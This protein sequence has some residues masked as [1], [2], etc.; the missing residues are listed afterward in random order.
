MIGYDSTPVLQHVNNK[1]I[2]DYIS[3]SWIKGA[4]YVQFD[5]SYVFDHSQSGKWSITKNNRGFWNIGLLGRVKLPFNFDISTDLYLYR[6]FG[7]VDRSMNSTDLLWT[8]QLGYSIKKDV[9]RITLDAYDILN[10]LKG[11]NYEVNA[12]GR[13][14]TVSSVLPRYLMLSVHYKFDFKPKRNN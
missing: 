2:S 5:G 13:T 6:R 9:C 8:A 11:I 7:Y 4:Y 12:T 10:Q 1:G 14:Q 3:L